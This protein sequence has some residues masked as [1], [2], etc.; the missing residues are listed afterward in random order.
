MPPPRL[1]RQFAVLGAILLGLAV[2]LRRDE[3]EPAIA[4]S[5]QVVRMSNHTALACLRLTTPSVRLRYPDDAEA[6]FREVRRALDPWAQKK[7]HRPH[8]SAKY[9]GPWVENVWITHFERELRRRPPG[10]PLSSV[11]GPFIPLL[12][13][14]TDR[15]VS[16]EARRR[17][18]ARAR[19]TP[20]SSHRSRLSRGWSARR[21]VSSSTRRSSSGRCGACCGPT[22]RTSP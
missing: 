7:G 19:Q 1:G 13:P 8:R 14:W 3:Q 16:R 17:G 21:A 6:H 9:R 20:E 4:S 10:S 5:S 18:G 11:F 22:C 12:V 15:F 2:L